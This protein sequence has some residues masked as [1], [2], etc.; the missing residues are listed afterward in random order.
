MYILFAGNTYCED[1][2]SASIKLISNSLT[3]IFNVITYTELDELG[4]EV[5]GFTVNDTKSTVNNGIYDWLEVFDINTKTIIF[6]IDNTDSIEDF[7]NQLQ[8]LYVYKS[9]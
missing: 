4:Y 8:Q 3:E 1:V 2:A 6:K 5:K 7:N 9:S